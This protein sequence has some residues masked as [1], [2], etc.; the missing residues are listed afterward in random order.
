MRQVKIIISWLLVIALMIFIYYF[1]DQRGVVSSNASNG[2]TKVI[3]DVF[4]L[5]SL[6][7][8]ES[9]HSF[10][11]KLAHFSVYAVLGVL[12]YNAIYCSFKTSYINILI[13]SMILIGMCAS[14]DE[15][16]QL[17]V[18]GRSC[19][20]RDVLIDCSGGSIGALLYYFKLKIGWF[21]NDL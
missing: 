6:F 21:K 12:V 9:F 14:F 4:N 3:F 8:F 13:Y 7:E 10:V 5:D 16:H 1:S 2:V 20:V 17:Y 11:R 19:E 15:I 18:L